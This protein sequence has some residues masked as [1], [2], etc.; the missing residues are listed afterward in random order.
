[1]FPFFPTIELSVDEGVEA[2]HVELVGHEEV[3]VVEADH[4]ELAPSAQPD[5]LWEAF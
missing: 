1:M 4:V 5:L 2:G 3:V